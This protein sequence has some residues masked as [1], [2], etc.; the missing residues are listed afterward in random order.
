MF[1]RSWCLRRTLRG[2][3]SPTVIIRYPKLAVHRH[4]AFSLRSPRSSPNR[5]SNITN[6]TTTVFTLTPSQSFLYETRLHHG[7]KTT[8]PCPSRRANPILVFHTCALVQAIKQLQRTRHPPGHI[9]QIRIQ[10]TS[11][12]KAP[13]CIHGFPRCRRRATIPLRC[14]SWELC[15]S[16]RIPRF[17]LH[18]Y[19]PQFSLHNSSS[20]FLFE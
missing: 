5:Q 7:P 18:L 9:Q 20:N 1:V 12:R 19:N 15:M 2:V 8:H 17:S 16:P 6:Q 14:A 11:T 3:A 4:L 13:R 10:N